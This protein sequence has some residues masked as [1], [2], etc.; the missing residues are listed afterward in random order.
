MPA[1]CFLI[2]LHLHARTRKRQ[3]MCLALA[4]SLVEEGKKVSRASER[5]ENG[6]IAESQEKKERR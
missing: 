5:A 4:L 6:L 1:S 3:N 2:H